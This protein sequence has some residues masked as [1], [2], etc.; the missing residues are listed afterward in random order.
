MQ[1]AEASMR[2]FRLTNDASNTFKGA[3][4]CIIKGERFYRVENGWSP[5][6]EN[7]TSRIYSNDRIEKGNKTQIGEIRERHGQKW[8]KISENNW[9]IVPESN[10]NKP[11]K[12][13]INFLYRNK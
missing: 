13:K 4:E 3:H 11:G 5:V 9:V 2:T 1:S 10:A 12:E 6:G 7:R 8:K